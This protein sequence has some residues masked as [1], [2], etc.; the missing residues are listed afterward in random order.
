MKIIT[1]S[2]KNSVQR[3]MEILQT[4]GVIVYPTDTLYG[5]GAD[6]TNESAIDK[7]NH[8]KG[9]AGPMSVMAA[10]KNMAIG[11]MDITN[12]QIE[13][14]EPYLGGAQT[15]IVPATPNIVNTKILGE[16][17]TLEIRIPSNKFCNEL[18]FQFGKPIISTSV[19]RAGEQP[20]ND[21]NQI[22]S[23]FGSEI[24]LI[25]DGGTSLESKG[26]TIYKLKDNNITILRK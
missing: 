20:M 10:N 15:L 9:R 17:N 1:Q 8:I 24:D 2:D 22:E 5:F 7:I 26:S 4:G 6:A 18:L 13:I 3:A 19:N 21:P 25:I 16:N 14:I 12:K 11:W 23:E